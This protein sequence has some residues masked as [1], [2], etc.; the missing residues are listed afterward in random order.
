M[1]NDLALAEAIIQK[2]IT[3]RGSIDEILSLKKD[4]N[5]DIIEINEILKL[6][7]DTRTIK[8]ID[9]KFVFIGK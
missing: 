2:I 3:N 1:D 7:I 5:T 9:N 4:Y 6:L 8:L